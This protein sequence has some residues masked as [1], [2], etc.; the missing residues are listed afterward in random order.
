QRP[1]IDRW[2]LSVRNSLV[3]RVNDYLERYDL[4][5]AARDISNFVIEDLSNWFVRRSRR[6]F[7]KSEMALDKL[8]AYQT[9][10][11][12]LMTVVKLIAPYT[13]FVAE[14]MYQNLNSIQKEDSESVHLTYYPSPKQAEYQFVDLELEDRMALARQIVS[15]ARALR[16]EVGTKV[17]QPLSQ[18][19]VVTKSPRQRQT[20]ET[21]TPIIKNEIN[22]KNV[23]ALTDASELVVQR[24]KPN[25]KSLG[26]KFGK[27]VNKI[28]EIIQK[29]SENQ[30]N[31][32]KTTGELTLRLENQEVRLTEEDVN[33][34]RQNREGLA[35]TSE[36]DLTIALDI[37]LN[38]ELI[39]EGLAREFVNRVQN[40]RKEA[41]FEVL[42][43]IRIYYKGTDKVDKAIQNQAEYIRNETLSEFIS[44]QYQPGEFAKQWHINQELVDIAIERIR[45]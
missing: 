43:R 32:L 27:N 23:V 30:I 26:P 1:E 14:E 6:R 12:T 3:I 9:L 20:I 36:G 29:L 34:F 2:I 28:A 11:E 5:R 7:W 35:V 37:R 15:L 4:T 13:P 39:E 24:A 21:M 41:G 40:M 45:S 19:L 16:S 25:F 33:I 42:D 22:V 8:S 31:Q 18:L 10:Y 38:E 17:R 44:N